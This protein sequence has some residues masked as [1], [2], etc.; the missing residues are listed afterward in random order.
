MIDGRHDETPAGINRSIDLQVAATG[1]AGRRDLDYAI[2]DDAEIIVGAGVAARIAR[3]LQLAFD[4]YAAGRIA[5]HLA[6]DDA[7]DVQRRLTR[8][9]EIDRMLGR[10]VAIL[11]LRR[12]QVGPAITAVGEEPDP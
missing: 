12:V 11:R 5:Q 7:F 6:G 9:D 2:A 8:A 3:V 10:L 4:H 1:D